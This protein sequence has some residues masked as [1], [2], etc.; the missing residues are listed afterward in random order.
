MDWQSGIGNHSSDIDECAHV[1]EGRR[2]DE[3]IGHRQKRLGRA[4]QPVDVCQHT[5]VV[6][7]GC[8]ACKDQPSG[9]ASI[10]EWQCQAHRGMALYLNYSLQETV[11]RK[12][13]DTFKAGEHRRLMLLLLRRVQSPSRREVRTLAH[14]RR[15]L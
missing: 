5:S 4:V 9:C 11:S 14:R 6:Q 8:T 7:F 10:Q 12:R 15:R 3:E 13:K 2:A 1:P